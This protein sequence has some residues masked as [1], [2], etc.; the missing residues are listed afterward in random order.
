MLELNPNLGTSPVLD[1]KFDSKRTQVAT[2]ELLSMRLSRDSRGRQGTKARTGTM[3]CTQ[4]WY[5]LICESKQRREESMGSHLN[6]R[7]P[8]HESKLESQSQY[9]LEQ[10]HLPSLKPTVPEESSTKYCSMYP[11]WDAEA[12]NRGYRSTLLDPLPQTR[13]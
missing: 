6:K 13:G 7:Y 10:E 4:Y 12:V 3:Y 11:G 2:S 8:R 9:G 1:A 5:T